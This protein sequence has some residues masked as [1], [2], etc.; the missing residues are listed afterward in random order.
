MTDPIAMIDGYVCDN[1]YPSMLHKCFQAPWIDAVLSINGVVPPRYNQ[2]TFTLFDLGCGDGLGLIL[3]AA[4]HPQGQFIGMDAAP[5]HIARGQAIIDAIGLTNIRLV[6]STFSEFRDSV[7]G[8]ADY[9]TANGVLAWVTLDNRQALLDLS[10]RLLKP[11]GAFCVGYNAFPGWNDV[12][13]FLNLIR[14]TAKEKTGNSTERFNAAWDHLRD[15]EIIGEG[16]WKWLEGMQ[17]RFSVSYFTQEYLNEGSLPCWSGDVITQMG[18][19]N[20]AYVG[21]ATNGR[22]REDLCFRQIWQDNLQSFDTVPARE[23]AADVY[24]N[25]WF[26]RDV[27]IKTPASGFDPEEVLAFRLQSWWMRADGQNDNVEMESSTLAGTL[28]FDTPLARAIWSGLKAGPQS[29]GTLTHSSDATP[30][31]IIDTI[32]AMFIAGLVVPVD[33]RQPDAQS[34]TCNAWFIAN[35]IAINGRAS[36]HGAY[37]VS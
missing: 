12:A 32:D 8:T 1:L 28:E 19:R 30:T 29:L 18:Q 31:Q 11:G 6:C 10:A 21:Q 35:N 26:R 22:L 34:D 4:S 7:E 13:P 14:A 23:I 33:A 16:V 9:V 27:F 36:K 24:C 5:D 2:E 37:C 15:M 3:A 17:E 20:L 25:S